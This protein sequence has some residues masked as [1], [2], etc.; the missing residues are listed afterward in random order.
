LPRESYCQIRDIFRKNVVFVRFTC[1][2]DTGLSIPVIPGPESRE[3][4]VGPDKPPHFRR[5]IQV[6]EAGVGN[7]EILIRR[8]P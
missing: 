2:V 4:R 8:D 5:I 6:M 3:F 1:P 7:D